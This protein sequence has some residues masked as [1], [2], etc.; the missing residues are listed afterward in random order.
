MKTIHLLKKL[1]QYPLFTENDVIKLIKKSPA[2]TRTLL[3]RLHRN[4]YIYRIERGK[5]TVHADALIFASYLATPSYIS[6]STALRYYNMIQQQPYSIFVMSPVPRKK[7]MFRGIPIL[8]ITIKSSTLFGYKKER[9]NDFDIFMADPEKVLIDSLRYKLPLS[10]IV[11]ALDTPEID[12]GRLSDYAYRLGNT[13]L[14]KR[15]G[16]VLEKKKGLS[17][18]LAAQ[19]HNY[20]PLDYLGKKKGKK[21]KKWKLIINTEL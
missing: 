13:S 7:V 3:Y 15:L 9:Y 19:D 18:G 21:D 2:Y 20:I 11:Q 5:Y 8:F 1:E 6:L 16:Y 14:I 12:F 17:Y 10:D 4:A